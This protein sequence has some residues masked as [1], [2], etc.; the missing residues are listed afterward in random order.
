M[1]FRTRLT[2]AAAL[3]IILII[4]VEFYHNHLSISRTDELS[5]VKNLKIAS[6]QVTHNLD[7]LLQE[8]ARDVTVVARSAFLNEPGRSTASIN[9][10]LNDFRKGSATIDRLTFVTATGRVAADSD[11]P[12]AL[13]TVQYEEIWKRGMAGE[14]GFTTRFQQQGTSGSLFFFA[15]V[16]QE[17]IDRPKGVIVASMEAQQFKELIACFNHYQTTGPQ[18]VR[19][20]LADEHGHL[21]CSTDSTAATLPVT[22]PP[23]PN[24]QSVSETDHSVTILTP[25]AELSSRTG[26][27][28]HLRVNAPKAQIYA[29][30]RDR[31]QKNTIV[32]VVLIVAGC[33]SIFLLARR[34]SKPLEELAEAVRLRGEGDPTPLL[35]LPERHDEFAL[36]QQNLQEMSTRLQDNTERLTASEARFHALFDNMG[37]GAALHRLVRDSTGTVSNYLILEVNQGFQTILGIP[38][39]QALGRLSTEL[40]QTGYPPYLEQFAEVVATGKPCSFEVYFAPLDRH[41]SISACPTTTDGFATIFSDITAKKWQ[42]DALRNT[43]A[44]LKSANQSKSRFLAVMSHEI[45]TPLNGITGMVQLLRDMEMPPLQRE[46]LDNIDSSAE[47]LLNV[48]NDILDF[49]KIEAGRLDLEELPFEPCKLLNNTLRVLRLRAQAK[50]L[51]LS[52]VCD[53]QLAPVLV[54][55]PHRLGQVL[56]NL[57]NNAIKFTVGGEIVVTA[58]TQELDQETVR[59][60]ISVR[61]PGIGMDEATQK[62]VFDPFTQ[63]DSSTTR[64]YGGTGLGLAICKQLMELMR[65][66]I[67]VTSKPAGGSTFTITVPLKRGVLPTVAEPAATAV[68]ALDHPLRILV[69]EDQPVNQRFVSEVLLKQGHTPILANNG[70]EAVELWQREQV[71]LVLMDIQMP[72]MDGLKA[73]AAIRAA[74]DGLKQHTPIVALTAHAIVGDRERLLEA[75]FDG[76]L[77]KP[78]QVAALFGE[79]ARVLE[80]IARERRP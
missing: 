78:L 12:A 76:Y 51:Q 14:S 67:S 55:D 32:L 80:Q 3:L 65:G 59:F 57:V 70:Q 39:E 16:R 18:P 72:V 29:Q 41:F 36:L 44:Q 43:M 34:F 71:D 20:E 27:S 77:P 52:L 68:T 11:D 26:S 35:E 54:G 45:R 24:Q 49:S 13:G 50:G 40:Y 46:F 31:L 22:E 15:P 33:S 2:L 38:R 69:A 1:K 4:S 25:A 53:E 61:D 8:S 62:T 66:S 60:S 19:I 37:E 56:I 58:G 28:W 42:E 73:L 74:E 21:L 30:I 79:M 23:A 64:K 9:R 5:A 7:L 63:A 17:D 75:G 6:L 48:I 10:R 47:S